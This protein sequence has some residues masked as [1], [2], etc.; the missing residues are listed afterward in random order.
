MSTSDVVYAIVFIDDEPEVITLGSL[1]TP[2]LAFSDSTY[3]DYI[4]EG[5]EVLL[6]PTFFK[7][8]QYAIGATNVINEMCT[9]E[10]PP[11]LLK[12]ALSI[13]TPINCAKIYDRLKNKKIVYAHVT[14][15]SLLINELRD[16]ANFAAPHVSYYAHMFAVLRPDTDFNVDTV[17]HTETSDIIA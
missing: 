3:M 7:K 1:A 16:G 10:G 17:Y 13:A 9:W 8:P 11:C 6:K 4:D 5:Y 15:N 14:K 12:V 2:S